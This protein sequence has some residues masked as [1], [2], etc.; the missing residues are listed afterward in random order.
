MKI[1]RKQSFVNN[2]LKTLVLG[3]LVVVASTNPLFGIKIIGAIQKDLKRKKWRDFYRNLGYLKRRGFIEV[4]QNSDGSYSVEATDSG[5][6]Q[7]ERYDLD[8]ITIKA[9]KKWDKQWRLIIFDIPVEKQKS[10]LALIPKLKEL[11]FIMLQKSVW[12]HPFECHNEVA[13]LARAF[14][15]DQYV[16]YITCSKVSS[17]DY[18]IGEFEKRNR[19]ILHDP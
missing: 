14:E 6:L 19:V 13:V 5:R 7:S 8:N 10:R 11:G 18:L 4:E 16:N 3:G 1:K 15:I 12:A 2:L 9:P 17:D